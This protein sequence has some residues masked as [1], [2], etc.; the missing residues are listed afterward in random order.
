MNYILFKIYYLLFN[1]FYLLRISYLNNKLTITDE[2]CKE[3][4]LDRRIKQKIRKALEYNSAK[5]I[6]TQDEKN[7][8][9]NE[10][11]I[12]LKFDVKKIK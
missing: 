2:F 4:K 1:I 3:A 5:I 8:F 12:N 9:L 6:F 7:E 11:P 10:I